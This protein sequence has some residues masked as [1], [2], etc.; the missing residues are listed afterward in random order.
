M[1][2][3]Q[4]P[5]DGDPEEIVALMSGELPFATLQVHG[6][7]SAVE[8][9]NVRC[10][11][12]FGDT[13]PQWMTDGGYFGPNSV[14]LGYECRVKGLVGF[15]GPAG[16]SA[17]AVKVLSDAFHQAVQDEGVLESIANIGLEPDYRDTEAYTAGL[18]ELVPVADELLHQLGFIAG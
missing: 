6:A 7:K 16:M 11:M 15:Y 13:T 18:E 10:I 12:I 5:Y 3:D 9:G 2:S 1:E 17:D 4:R 14:E 8:A